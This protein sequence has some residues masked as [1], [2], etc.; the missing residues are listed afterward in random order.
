[1]K[2]VMFVL[3]CLLLQLSSTAFAAEDFYW[4][5]SYGR[6]VGTV[7]PLIC[8]GNTEQDAGLCYEKCRDG[9]KGVGPL[10]NLSETG[11]YGR[12]AGKAMSFHKGK[13]DCDKK[14]DKDGGLCYNKCRDGYHGVGPVCYNN[15]A[16]SYGRGAGKVMASVCLNGEQK[17]AGLCYPACR[18]YY[19][20]V[21]PVCWSNSPTNWVPCG[22]GVARSQGDCGV[23]IADQ[24]ASVLLPALAVVPA[25]TKEAAAS[26]IASKT[27]QFGI[28]AEKITGDLPAMIKLG[29]KIVAET[30][31]Q[32][33]AIVKA[34]K[35]GKVV[36]AADLK[37]MAINALAAMLEEVPTLAFRKGAMA[38]A[39]LEAAV[40]AALQDYRVQ[41][42]GKW[43][44]TEGPFDLYLFVSGVQEVTDDSDA[45][46]VAILRNT[47]GFLSFTLAMGEMTFGADLAV[48]AA[49]FGVVSA[50]SYSIYEVP[51]N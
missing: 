20:G 44:V 32:S 2:L 1:M 28:W 24:V 37:S 43:A 27:H 35:S 10:C 8:E 33:N 5:D 31:E 6:G 19:S 22:A 50:Y 15:N 51:K 30:G 17:D 12:G 41:K 3:T 4:R 26:M 40:K 11:S 29:T 25:T 16:P 42:A 38:G 21:G 14:D 9:Y 46:W 36:A 48:P 23:I 7:P 39:E 47:A 34:A 45:A 49:V 13:L 18:H